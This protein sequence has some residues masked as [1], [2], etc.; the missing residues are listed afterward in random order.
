ERQQRGP[1]AVG[2]QRIC[3]GS[4]RGFRAQVRALYRTAGHQGRHDRRK[5][6]L[7]PA[8][9]DPDQGGL[10]RAGSH[11]GHPGADKRMDLACK[12]T[13]SDREFRGTARQLFGIVRR[14]GRRGP[15][16]PADC[17]GQAVHQKAYGRP[18]DCPEGAQMGHRG[19]GQPRPEGPGVY[20]LEAALHGPAGCESDCVVRQTPHLYG[21]RQ[22][23]AGAAWHPPVADRQHSFDLLQAANV[24][25]A[26]RQASRPDAKPGTERA[27]PVLARVTLAATGAAAAASPDER[28][29]SFFSRIA[30]SRLSFING[31]G[32][33]P[34]ARW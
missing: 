2:A 12:I 14:R 17:R 24:F 15:A 33:F 25:R 7:G 22:H 19:N 20:L 6:H 32:A 10:R 18:G 29:V 13:T 16:R 9:P 21:I 1:G 26:E 31:A 8:G 27:S 3:D 30:H 4:G 34:R 5:V 28:T 11:R 23:G